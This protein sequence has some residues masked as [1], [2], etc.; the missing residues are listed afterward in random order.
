LS[1]EANLKNPG[2]A[3]KAECPTRD[4]SAGCRAPS[5]HFF[6]ARRLSRV[7]LLLGYF[8]YLFRFQAEKAIF[9]L[10]GRVFQ[11]YLLE[12]NFAKNTAMVKVSHLFEWV[13]DE[14]LQQ[15]FQKFGLVEDAYVM[16]DPKT[17][18]SK[19]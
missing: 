10:N 13:T 1:S 17:K 14:M 16:I 15:S 8:I 6:R 7:S 11:N 3:P 19:K 4:P 12:V 18:K 5:A 2:A 9:E